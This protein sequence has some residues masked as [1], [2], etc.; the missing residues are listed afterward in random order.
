MSRSGVVTTLNLGALGLSAVLLGGGCSTSEPIYTPIKYVEQ[1][2]TREQMRDVLVTSARDLGWWVD[3]R[4]PGIV[5]AS[6]RDGD[7]VAEIEMQYNAERYSIYYKNSAALRDEDSG[8]Y[9]I[10]APYNEW[11]QDLEEAINERLEKLK[12][13]KVRA[14][15]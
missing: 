3:D 12:E 14:G 7:K 9:E 5:R 1:H 13:E 11:V 8:F 6:Y 10:R 2:L 4:N 15:K